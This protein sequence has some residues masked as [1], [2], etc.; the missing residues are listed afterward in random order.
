MGAAGAAV[1]PKGWE[2]GAAVLAAVAFP[3]GVLVVVDPKGAGGLEAAGAVVPKGV[4]AGG[5]EGAGAAPPKG[6]AGAPNGFEAGVVVVFPKGVAAGGC[7][8][9]AGAAKAVGD[10]KLLA[11]DAKP[12]EEIVGA[13]LPPKGL[14]G[15]GAVEPKAVG[16]GLLLAGFP[17]APPPKGFVCG[18]C[19]CVVVPPKGDPNA[20]GGFMAACGALANGM[21]GAGE[22]APKGG[23]APKGLAFPKAGAG[24][25]APPP[26]KG[27]AGGG[28][29][30]GLLLLLAD[31]NP[32][33]P[34]MAIR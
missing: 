21:E 33:K 18:C 14:A 19:C 25:E 9:V 24:G 5:P 3:N 11:D 13:V 26:A 10:A 6:P 20:A 29:P 15:G 32:P 4:R 27:A 17:K 16:W 12:L 31:P 7:H 28:A 2:G 1:D 8:A 34:A 22:D 30:K 23:A